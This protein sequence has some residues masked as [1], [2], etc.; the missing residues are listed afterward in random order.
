MTPRERLVVHTG[1]I[2]LAD[3]ER[4]MAARKIGRFPRQP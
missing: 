2:S 3:A 4:V 1:Q